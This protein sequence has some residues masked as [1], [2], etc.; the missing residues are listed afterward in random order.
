MH[1]LNGTI[2]GLCVDTTRYTFYGTKTE[3]FANNGITEQRRFINGDY[4]NILLLKD[5]PVCECI[6]LGILGI[7]DYSQLLKYFRNY[8]VY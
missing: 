1:A 4:P 8:Q 5:P 3:A 7:H 6:G 2:V